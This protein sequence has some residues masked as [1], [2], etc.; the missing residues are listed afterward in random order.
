MPAKSPLLGSQISP[1]QYSFYGD[2]NYQIL[3]QIEQVSVEDEEI[4]VINYSDPTILIQSA[5]MI[6]FYRFEVGNQIEENPEV[7]ISIDD[8]FVMRV[9]RSKEYKLKYLSKCI[10]EPESFLQ[11]CIQFLNEVLKNG[12]LLTSH[13][14]NVDSLLSL[15]KRSKDS[16]DFQYFF[17]TIEFYFIKIGMK[18]LSLGLFEPS[19]KIAIEM[20]SQHLLNTIAMFARGQKNVSILALVN[21]IKEQ[22]NPGSSNINLVKSMEQIAN[23]SK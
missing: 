22:W 13:R 4:K 23:F 9:L 11:C 5:T 7:P 15:Y 1:N 2:N 19:L 21:Y 10:Y 3:P 17:H 14:I 12:L 16:S 20:K 6:R 18:F 8:V